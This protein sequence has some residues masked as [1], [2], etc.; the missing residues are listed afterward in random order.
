MEGGGGGDA[1]GGG[2][3]VE[4]ASE[5]AYRRALWRSGFFGA[6]ISLLPPHG[7]PSN[8]EFRTLS[9]YYCLGLVQ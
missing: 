9:R 2:R 4:F 5:L 3:V 7:T 6:V 1:G 8:R